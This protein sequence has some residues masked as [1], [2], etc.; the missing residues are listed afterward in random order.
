MDHLSRSRLNCFS[1]I[2]FERAAEKRR[3]ERWLAERMQDPLTAFV[4]LWRSRTLIQADAQRGAA[5]LTSGDLA[6][7]SISDESVVLLGEHG[8]RCYVAIDLPGADETIADTLADF[9]NFEELRGIAPLLDDDQAGLLA[10]AQAMS[11]WH[12]R[13]RYCGDCGSTTRSQHAGS[14]RVCTNEHCARQQFPRTDPAVIVLVS[15]GDRC[16]LGRQPSWPPGMYSSLAGFVE[17]GESLEDAVIREV[18]EESGIVVGEIYYHSSQPWPFPASI[19][20]G[21]SAR[22]TND[23]ITLHDDE[24][25]EARWFSRDELADSIHRGE[26]KTPTRVSIAYRLLE[27]WFDAGSKVKLA[28]LANPPLS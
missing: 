11:Y 17:P 28:E 12:R 2:A 8:G 19:M 15:H 20:L 13:H 22:A 3:D 16:L 25:E 27:D 1:R 18:Y 14:T 9:G 4:P 24:L 23:T 6:G 10:Y 26:V 21:F 5:L 7:I